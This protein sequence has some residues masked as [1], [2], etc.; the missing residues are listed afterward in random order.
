MP[1]W[2]RERTGNFRIYVTISPYLPRRGLAS[3]TTGTCCST[4]FLASASPSPSGCNRAARLTRSR[5]PRDRPAG[6]PDRPCY[7]CFIRSR[8]GI[9][10]SYNDNPAPAQG[11]DARIDI[12]RLWQ[13]HG[14]RYGARFAVQLPA[15]SGMRQ[16]TDPVAPSSVT[17]RKE[18]AKKYRFGDD[19]AHGH[20]S[21]EPAFHSRSLHGALP[22]RL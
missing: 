22:P 14:C 21:G 18:R 1:D 10:G 16:T 5:Q 3:R 17:P 11:A 12:V 4:A 9:A 6:L 15:T 2:I 7:P 19:P 13:F 8:S 20:E